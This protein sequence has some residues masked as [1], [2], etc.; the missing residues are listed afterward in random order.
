MGFCMLRSVVVGS[1]GKRDKEENMGGI[2]VANKTHYKDWEAKLQRVWRKKEKTGYITIV[3]DMFAHENRYEVHREGKPYAFDRTYDS[4]D[5]AISMAEASMLEGES[6]YISP[7]D[8]EFLESR[9]LT[10]HEQI[11][12]D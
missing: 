5:E 1:T 9:P 10:G 11:E 7:A 2:Q 4:L 3:E 8:N 12:I 6:M